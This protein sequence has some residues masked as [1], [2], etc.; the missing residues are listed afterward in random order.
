MA[1]WRELLTEKPTLELDYRPEA[2]QGDEANLEL[3]DVHVQESETVQ[4]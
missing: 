3:R 2:L 1:D 4:L